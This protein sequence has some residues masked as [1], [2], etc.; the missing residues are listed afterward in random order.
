[1]KSWMWVVVGVMAVGL[2]FGQTFDPK[3]GLYDVARVVVDGKTNMIAGANYKALYKMTPQERSAQWPYLDQQF[4]AVTNGPGLEHE[5]VQFVLSGE[6]KFKGNWEA[7][8]SPVACR[9]VHATRIL[10]SCGRVTAGGVAVLKEVVKKHAVQQAR[11]RL[12]AQG[13]TPVA[14]DGVNPLT[15]LVEPVIAALNA[16]ACAGLI[17][18]M[19]AIGITDLTDG[20]VLPAFVPPDTKRF[21]EL[22][23]AAKQAVVATGDPLAQG[24]LLLLLGVDGYN[25]FVRQF[26]E[27]L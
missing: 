14:K 12:F 22:I 21:G 1:M 16:P 24:Q 13:K 6:G 27:G 10:A 3:R 19:A 11:L 7:K 15:V 20:G 2:A 18:A 26:N 5:R 4:I 25:R 8:L 9:P 23:D 17:E